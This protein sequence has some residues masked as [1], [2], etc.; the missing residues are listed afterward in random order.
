MGKSQE[1]ANKL[2]FAA[3]QSTAGWRHLCQI[4]E[5]ILVVI[6]ELTLTDF[7]GV[8]KLSPFKWFKSL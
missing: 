4:Y 7:P 6:I 8:K 5:K 2:G 3:K 1:S